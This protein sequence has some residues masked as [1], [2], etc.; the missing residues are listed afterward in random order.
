MAIMNKKYAPFSQKIY[1][2]F[3]FTSI[4]YRLEI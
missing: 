1:L 3:D 2:L 4:N